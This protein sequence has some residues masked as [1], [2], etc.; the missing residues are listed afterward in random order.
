GT[1]AT[2]ARPRMVV[3]RQENESWVFAVDEVDQVYRI[4]GGSLTPAPP[5]LSR[6]AARITR[7]VFT[8]N[9]RSVGLLD[10]GRLFRAIREPVR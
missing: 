8:S 1:P 3:I 7:G 6:S 9:D 5:T 10:D 4:P 2:P